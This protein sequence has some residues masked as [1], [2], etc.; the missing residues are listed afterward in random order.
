MAAMSERDA[1]SLSNDHTSCNVEVGTADIFVKAN[2]G[3]LVPLVSVDAPATVPGTAGTTLLVVPRINSQVSIVNTNDGDSSTYE[4]ALARHLDFASGSN[5][6]D[7]YQQQVESYFTERQQIAA[8][9]TKLDTENLDRSYRR[10]ALAIKK[11]SAELDEP[12]DDPLTA[13]IRLIG[14]FEGFEVRKELFTP[15][16]A[17]LIHRIQ[18]IAHASGIRVRP[19][20]LS[21]NW[22]AP[23][24]HAFLALDQSTPGGT[25][26]A[27][28]PTNKGYT[29]QRGPLDEPK[30][31]TS[32][33]MANINTNGMQFY[34]TL[35]RD[36]P[37]T[38]K[39]V[40]KLA[41]RGMRREWLWTAGLAAIVAILGLLTPILTNV[42]L[43]SIVPNRDEDLL[44]QAGFA[45][46][47]AALAAG[48]FSFVQ[49]RA[50]SRI[51]QR[52]IERVQTAFWDR[53]LAMPVAFFDKFSSGDLSVR[54]MAVDAFQQIINVQV[55][56]GILA[57]IFAL[58]NLGLMFY[59]DVMLGIAGLL[60]IIVTIFIGAMAVRTV[61]KLY[62][63]SINAQLASTSWV[64]QV[65]SGI[66]K[67]R[68]AGAT[69]R[70][71]GRYLDMVRD[72][73]VAI[74]RMTNVFGKVQGWTLFATSFATALFILLIKLRSGTGAPDVSSATF[75]ALLSAFGA[76][77]GALTALTSVLL[78]IGSAEPIFRLLRPIM[79]DVPAVT[80]DKSA[81]GR[82]KGDI[83][84]VKV[85]YRYEK[86][87]PVVLD[88]L[89]FHVKPGE[90]VAI[91]GPSGSGKS[92]TIRL[93]LGFDHPD[94]G[95]VLFDNRMLSDL[96]PDLVR[97]Q[98]GVVVQ[99][100]QIMRA[101]VMQNI[102]GGANFDEGAA[103][104]AAEE[105]ALAE[106]IRAMP[107]GM[108]TL[109]DP[110]LLSGGQAQRILLARALVRNP[111]IIIM[112]EATSAL[113][114]VAQAKVTAAMDALGATRIV[115][116]H[117]LSTIEKADRILVIV[118]GQVVEQGT[119]AELWAKNGEFA[120]LARR[121]VTGSQADVIT[122]QTHL[123][124]TKTASTDSQDSSS[125]TDP[126]E[127]SG[128][129]TSGSGVKPTKSSATSGSTSHKKTSGSTS[130]KK[131]SGSTSH[132]KTSGSTSHK[133]TESQK[134]PKPQSKTPKET[135]KATAQPK[136]SKSGPQ[137][138]KD[139]SGKTTP[140]SDESNN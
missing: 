81:P 60:I 136:K 87:L 105:A 59:Y 33:D 91:T 76:S 49:Y 132:K 116:A 130:H 68:L 111:S 19:V 17:D 77:F 2:S 85:R 89:S 29:I 82:L 37:V 21:G 46:A 108:H 67:V 32:A 137:A 50:M 90:M 42:V 99:D 53:V 31:L 140:P 54:V 103:W 79:D 18:G 124:S 121:D 8:E 43:G 86:E 93:L 26:V 112:D 65:L 52:A 41:V 55:I 127:G 133:T 72:Q 120:K 92:T 30:P 47:A 135:D 123:E 40:A 57:A 44:A 14:R 66:S 6:A 78:P 102:M 38:S 34:A 11:P 71:E 39:D 74:S 110:T 16:G 3:T 107:M 95:Q 69:T 131:T 15:K 61:Q 10:A 73:V 51:S 83:Q 118:A 13:V 98:M 20:D 35:D 70:M 25:P 119:Y 36:R 9:S 58:V 115:V 27:L 114:N 63:Q 139:K 104:R 22:Q 97:Q 12:Q 1:V 134:Q 126:S 109:V 5:L 7:F 100:G 56:G 4:S 106:D 64:I 96:D 45:L 62:W 122:Q 88:D 129:P 75:L 101:T 128:P 48:V 84:F 117:R 23:R 125:P 113:D 28:I 138:D 80:S 94:D 24:A